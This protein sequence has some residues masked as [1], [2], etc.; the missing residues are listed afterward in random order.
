MMTD[1]PPPFD[2]TWFRLLLG[3]I[4]GAALGSFATM[5]AYRLPRKMSIIVPD[6]HCPS[7]ST[8]LRARDLI[9][10]LSWL[11]TRGKCRICH[12]SIGIRYLLI[13]FA[14]ACACA[15]LTAA[16]GFTPVVLVAY[17]VVVALVVITAHAL[18]RS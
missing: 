8:P 11:A 10:M 2:A 9:P 14:S 1:L 5:L 18:S 7:C 6:S 12:A 13:E 4:I 16:F 3:F 15:I 17:A